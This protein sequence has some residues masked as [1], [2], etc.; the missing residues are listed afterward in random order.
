MTNQFGA[1][2][3]LVGLIINKFA[4]QATYYESFDRQLGRFY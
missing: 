2:L 4:S 3:G 1:E